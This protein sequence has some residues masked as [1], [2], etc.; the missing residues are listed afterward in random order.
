MQAV[1][2]DRVKLGGFWKNRFDIN[3]AVTIPTVYDRFSDTG[4]FDAFKFEWKE[5]QPKKPHIFWDSDVAKW[6]EAVAYTVTLC[7]DKELEAVVDG[8]VDLIEKNQG[9]DGYFNI[10]YTVCEPENRFTNRM[11][12]ELYCAG[13]LTEAAVAYYKATGKDKFLRLMQKYMDYIEKVFIIED[14]ASF[15]TP[16]HEEIELALVKLYDCTGE[17]KYLD[18]SRHFVDTRGTSKKD[19]DS[20]YYI[21]HAYD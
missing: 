8:V 7:P 19:E 16:G 9:D 17:K 14:S 21:S 20:P 5:G 1:T 11:Q 10:Y 18:M 2:F 3:K 12:H 4:R 6:I 15:N 13:H